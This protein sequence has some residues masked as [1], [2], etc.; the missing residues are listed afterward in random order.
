MNE[1][2]VW[3]FIKGLLSFRR[4]QVPAIPPLPDNGRQSPPVV[5][6][7]EMDDGQSPLTALVDVSSEHMN[8]ANLAEAAPVQTA[9]RKRVRAIDLPWFSSLALLLAL[10]A[11]RS[12]EP[13]PDQDRSWTIGLVLYVIAFLCGVLALLRKEWMTAEAEAPAEITQFPTIRWPWLIASLPFMLAAFLAFGESAQGGHRFT[14]LNL[15][16]WLAAVFTMVMALLPPLGWGWLRKFTQFRSWQIRFTPFVLLFVGVLAVSAFYRFYDLSGVP[17][18]MNSDHAEKL[19]DVYDVLTGNYFTFFPRNTGR[20]A[21]QFYLTAFVAKLFGTGVSFM[22]LKIGTA[23]AG[24][25]TLPFIYL[26]GKE[27]G[28]RRV[29]LIAMF[30]GGIAFWPNILSRVALRFTLYPLFVAP[31][32]YFLLRGLR[33]SSVKDFVLSGIFLGI[34]LHGYTPIRILPFIIVAAVAIFLIHR[35]TSDRRKMAVYGL[36]VVTLVSVV[37]ALP[38]L[39]VAVDLPDA[40]A[41]RAF[42]RLGEVEQGYQEPVLKTLAVNTWRAMVMPLWDSNNIWVVAVTG[43]PALD[44]ASGA[45]YSLGFVMLIVRYGLRRRWQDLFLVLSVPML[46]LPSILSLAFPAE[47]PAPNRAG[48]AMVIIFVIAAL[49]F[50]GILRAIQE[51]F[52]PLIGKFIAVVTV[53]FLLLW[54]G[55]QNYVLVFEQYRTQYAGGAWNTTELGEVISNFTHS[56]GSPENAW[57]VAYPYWVDTRLVGMNAG[58]PARDYAIQPEDLARSAE[59]TGAKLFIVNLE[60]AASLDQLRAMYPN[61]WQVEYQSKYE[62]KNFWVYFVPP[63]TGVTVP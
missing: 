15:V 58:D 54:S 49:A 3:D 4:D 56:I 1:P 30:L 9:V 35:Q 33:R 62:N 22:S 43:R 52:S 17:P 46:M 63:D 2:S 13:V 28:N 45:L 20:E 48:G 57:V 21:L 31:A 24:M 8:D 14:A 39:R 55:V 25:L 38:L 16:L 44:I 12:L 37:V 26:L 27:I 29:G 61:G 50:D 11:Q 7:E 47:N 34:G 10:I 32:L 53:V 6:Q 59:T 41:F 51:R 36:L 60:D 23:V 19:Q 18:E 5:E 42:S 40:F